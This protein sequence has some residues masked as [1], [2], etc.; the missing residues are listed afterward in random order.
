[1]KLLAY[2]DGGGMYEDRHANIG[3]VLIDQA[4]GEICVEY[5]YS[6]GRATNNEAEYSAV[7]SAIYV[8][9]E[10]GATELEVRSD[11]KLIVNQLNGEWRVHESH[12]KHYF[13]EVRQEADKLD[14]FGIQWIPRAEN[15]YADSLSR[16]VVE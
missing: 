9:Q 10:L 7:L 6:I 4:T 16:G 13:E 5:G 12:L 15:K 11:S 14:K 8:A 2:V 1:M 3:V